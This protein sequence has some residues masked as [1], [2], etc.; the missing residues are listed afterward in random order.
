MTHV[1]IERIQ[2]AAGFSAAKEMVN[3]HHSY[4]KWADRPSRKCYYRIIADG[5]FVGVFGLGSAFSKPKAVATFMTTHG[6][7]FNEMANNIVYCLRPHEDKNL[8]TKI[9]KAIRT[10]A[11]LWWR[12]RYGDTMKAMQTFILPPRTGA[13][14]KA[15]NWLSLGVTVG[16]TVMRSTT[17]PVHPDN[18]DNPKIEVRTF[19]NGQIRHIL[20]T[21]VPGESKL[22]FVR[23]LDAKAN[24]RACKI[25]SCTP[26]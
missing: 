20:R 21:R 15:D 1:S 25:G 24:Q 8:G 4:I 11:P 2:T 9:L 10:D 18:F 23:L 6:I 12:E 7:A 16:G 22:I 14:Y 3:T 13:M 26:N 19:R 5:E 17:V